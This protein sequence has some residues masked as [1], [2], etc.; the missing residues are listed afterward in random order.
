MVSCAGHDEAWTIGVPS[1]CRCGRRGVDG[2]REDGKR[3]AV[4]MAHRSGREKERERKGGA[5][6]GD[7]RTVREGRERDPAH[8]TQTQTERERC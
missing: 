4:N 5:G 7:G 6:S 8:N 1:V 3:E 2:W